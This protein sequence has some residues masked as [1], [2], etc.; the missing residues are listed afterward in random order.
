LWQ[1]A[2]ETAR[3]D[4]AYDPPDTVLRQARAAFS[5]HHPASRPALDAS[6]VFDSLLQALPAGVRSASAGPRQLLY[7]AGR[8]A[9]RLRAEGDPRTGRVVLVGQVVDEDVPGSFV[10]PVTVMVFDGKEAI[11][12][13]VTND[14]GEFAFDD[15]PAGAL[16]LAVGVP[17]ERFLTV[18]LPV[19][20]GDAGEVPAAPRGKRL[21]LK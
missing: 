17:E 10:P 16:R 13:T 12:Q 18:A 4:R 11:D 9:I 20:G 5:L 2:V 21:N 6:L 19:L 1:G 14:F 3:R 15:A 7:K 8:Y